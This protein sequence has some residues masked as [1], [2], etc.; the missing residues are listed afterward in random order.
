MTDTRVYIAT[1]EGPALVQRLAPEEGLAEAALSAV[2]LDGTTTRLPIT[3]AYTY[4]VRDHVRE[5]SGVDAYRL[6]LDRRVDGG[7]SWMLGAWVAHLLLAENRLAMR[8]DKAETAIFATGEVGL[9]RRRRQKG[10]GP[11]RRP[12]GGEGGA[13]RRT[14][15]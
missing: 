12:R 9:L 2:C 14:G 3:G 11:A 10:R 4:F 13:P 15:E 6:D 5:L 1:T 7:A 8:D